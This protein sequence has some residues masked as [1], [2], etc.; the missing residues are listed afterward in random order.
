MAFKTKGALKQ[1]MQMNIIDQI[2]FG[3]AGGCTVMFMV[4]LG[5]IVFQLSGKIRLNEN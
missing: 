4:G 1:E 5:A 2:L 3:I